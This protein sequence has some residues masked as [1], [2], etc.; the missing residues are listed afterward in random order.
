MKEI[1]LKVPIYCV[2]GIVALIVAM[3]TADCRGVGQFFSNS[4]RQAW[5]HFLVLMGLGVIVV[6]NVFI[7]WALTAMEQR[8][9]TREPSAVAGGQ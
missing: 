6:Q 1:A 3:G 8:H 9:E 5:F 4:G 7:R 2:L